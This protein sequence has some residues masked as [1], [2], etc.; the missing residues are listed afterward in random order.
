MFVIGG[1]RLP[2]RPGGCGRLGCAVDGP[3][4]P[5]ELRHAAAC[6]RRA[7]ADLRVAYR[8]A[9]FA[10]F[11][12]AVE[13]DAGGVAETGKGLAQAQPVP[14]GCVRID[15]ALAGGG[16][17]PEIF[18]ET[19]RVTLGKP[20]T[21]RVGAAEGRSLGQGGARKGAGVQEDG[22]NGNGL[23]RRL[24]EDA[25]PRRAR[26]CTPTTPSAGCCGRLTTLTYVPE[27]APPRRSLWH[28]LEDERRRR[29]KARPGKRLG[30][31]AGRPCRGSGGRTG[32]VRGLPRPANARAR[33]P[34]VYFPALPG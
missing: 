10:R 2:G 31:S 16:T 18:G 25:W 34:T 13:V 32:R 33:R 8:C 15:A 5:Q 23:F 9:A 27:S 20:A 28:S 29:L 24:G 17:S 21:S 26:R 7:L 12:D 22:S 4:S 14:A 1:L 11:Y 6:H 19:V 3:R 30:P